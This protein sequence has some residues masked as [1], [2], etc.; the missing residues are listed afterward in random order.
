MM[1]IYA[2]MKRRNILMKVA[3][4]FLNE[5]RTFISNVLIQYAEEEQKSTRCTRK[6]SPR[7]KKIRLRNHQ[8]NCKINVH[9][10]IKQNKYGI[11]S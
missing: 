11:W 4:Q 6:T 1:E 9:K 8:S 10:I 3:S 5:S 7:V 2:Y